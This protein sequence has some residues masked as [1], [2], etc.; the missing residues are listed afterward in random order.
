M[1]IEDQNNSQLNQILPFSYKRTL[2]HSAVL[3]GA[4]SAWDDKSRGFSTQDDE[5]SV[6]TSGLSA[7]EM[8]DA[9]SGKHLGNLSDKS[10]VNLA[11]KR[12]NFRPVLKTNSQSSTVFIN[13]TPLP[14]T[15]SNGFTYKADRTPT[16]PKG[17][18]TIRVITYSKSGLRGMLA[19]R[20]ISFKVI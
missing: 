2:K 14:I 10:T 5:N 12:V 17:N 6:Y 8:W 19:H 4:T 13:G 18:H 3:L 11:N 7:L 9:N 20:D 1:I 16:L 15:S